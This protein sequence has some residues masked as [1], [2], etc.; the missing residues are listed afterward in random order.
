MSDENQEY[1]PGESYTESEQ[2]FVDTD[3]PTMESY[4]PST[5]DSMM[6]YVPSGQSSSATQQYQQPQGNTPMQGFID[7]NQLGQ[8]QA[9]NQAQN[10]SAQQN[11]PNQ[12]YQQNLSDMNQIA[13]GPNTMS[14]HKNL[15][16][17]ENAMGM[18]QDIAST[19]KKEG[20]TNR[21]YA[22]DVALKSLYAAV[23]SLEEIE[24]WIPE[25]KEEYVPKLNQIAKPIKE[26]LSQY[27]AYIERLK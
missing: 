20:D 3:I 13:P 26:A 7:L 15:E 11:N 18:V 4:N 9:Q 21:V 6:P 27:T 25:G 23:S 12:Q 1:Q 8:N 10:E 24:Y 5:D 22:T 2:Q 17:L 16:L 14:A 19:T